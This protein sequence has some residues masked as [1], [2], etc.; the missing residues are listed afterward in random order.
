[1]VKSKK[2]ATP[3]F[4]V[5]LVKRALAE[6]SQGQ[7]V[8]EPVLV[9]L[10]GQRHL[11]GVGKPTKAALEKLAAYL[12]VSV[13]WLQGNFFTKQGRIEFDVTEPTAIC[14]KCGG[15]LRVSPEGLD[16]VLPDGTEIEGDG[17]LRIWPCDHCCPGT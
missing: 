2:I 15:A 8:R 13:V 11:K 3:E 16:Q 12:G 7:E 10:T 9:S 4:I 5:E 6:K 1:M 14:A 17:V